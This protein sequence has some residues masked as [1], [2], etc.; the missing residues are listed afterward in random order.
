MN[1]QLIFIVLL[2]FV[3]SSVLLGKTHQMW[4]ESGQ[5]AWHG[6]NKYM[7]PVAHALCKAKGKTLASIDDLYKAN[8][9]RTEMGWLRDGVAAKKHDRNV[10]GGKFHPEL[11]FG[12]FCK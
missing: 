7:Y 1:N 12:V 3:L 10:T 2:I 6:P 4:S 5:I 11:R 9:Q 8:I